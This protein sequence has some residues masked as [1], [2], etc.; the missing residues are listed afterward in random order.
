MNKNGRI[1][2]R[3]SSKNQTN[4][5]SL[6]AQNEECVTFARQNNINII[7]VYQD[8]GSAWHERNLPGMKKLLEE[9]CNNEI[10]IIAEVSRFSRNIRIA[11]INLN[12]LGSKNVHIFSVRDHHR[13]DTTWNR[14][15][16]GHNMNY[17]NAMM[18]AR[19]ESDLISQ[20]VRSSIDLKRKRGD[21]LGVIPFGFEKSI[22]N[23]KQ[24]LVSNKN[25]VNII[26][27]VV[28]LFND[29]G[30]SLQDI[31]SLFQ[32]KNIKKRNKNFTINMVKKI[33]KDNHKNFKMS[34]LKNQLNL[35][36]KK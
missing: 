17:I 4:G 6:E 21:I 32:N 26:N 8:I 16:S 22:E 23:G 11:H 10:I 1:Y 2:T 35:L 12:Q 5:M 3:I 28:K 9:I 14:E 34:N 30:K 33:I 15:N 27:Q 36:L 29:K 7:G 19:A 24:I 18:V 20:R 31:V 25:E 13:F